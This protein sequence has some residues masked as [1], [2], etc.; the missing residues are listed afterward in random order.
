MDWIKNFSSL[1]QAYLYITSYKSKK[2]YHHH[3]SHQIEHIFLPLLIHV[4]ME[5]FLLLFL[6]RNGL[7]YFCCL[8]SRLYGAHLALIHLFL[9]FFLMMPC[10]WFVNQ[11]VFEMFFNKCYRSNKWTLHV[12]TTLRAVYFHFSLMFCLQS[13]ISFT[14]S[15]FS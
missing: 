12:P 5:C 9:S 2:C 15:H 4:S 7:Y 6:R 10:L 8:W 14:L 11:S 1:S 13:F 3:H